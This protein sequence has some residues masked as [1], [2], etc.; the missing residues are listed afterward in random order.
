MRALTILSVVF[1]AGIGVGFYLPVPPWAAVGALATAAVAVYGSL[2]LQ[3]FTALA[4][5]AT[6]FACGWARPAVE[7]ENPDHRPLPPCHRLVQGRLASPPT[8]L[9]ERTRLVLD[10]ESW[11]A[12]LSSPKVD[13]LTAVKGRLM[14]TIAGNGPVMFRPGDRL[15]LRAKIKSVALPSNPGVEANPPTSPFFTAFVRS[16]AAIALVEAGAWN[17]SHY[18]DE[19]RR[20][21]AAFWHRVLEPAKANMARALTL[22][23]TAALGHAARQCFRRTGTA[24]LLSVSG[25]H[26]GLVV[27]FAYSLIRFLLIRITPLAQRTDVG[28]IAAACA[29]PAAVSFALL[30][31]CRIPVVRASVMATSALGA[32]MSSRP[33]GTLEAMAIA[34][35]ALLIWDPKSLFDP[36]FQLSFAAVI[37]FVATLPT[38]REEDWL[39]IAPVSQSKPSLFRRQGLI[40]YEFIRVLFRS[41]LAAAAATTPIV[42]VHFGYVSLVAV[43]ANVVAV[44]L[45]GF[46]IMPGLLVA[47]LFAGSF[48]VFAGWIGKL[49]G[50]VLGVL[51]GFL[52]KISYLPCTLENPG[53]LMQCAVV[54][55]SAGI[56]FYLAQ[57]VR[58]GIGCAIA[59]V[60]FCTA[61]WFMDPPPFPAGKLTVDFLDVGQGDATLITFPNGAHWLVDSGGSTSTWYDVGERIVV[62][63][64]R[65]LG[66]TRIDKLILT[67]PDRDHVGG[68]PALLRAVDV[69]EIWENGQGEAE[70]ADDTYH[71]ALR[72]ARVRGIAIR[73]TPA[74]CGDLSVSGVRASVLHPCSRGQSYDPTLS[75]NDNSL[76]LQLSY[77]LVT[78][79]LPGDIEREVEKF[80]AER[81]SLSPVDV[82]KLPHH[83]SR[84]SSS[85]AFLDTTKP[86]IA[87]ASLGL[88][89]PYGIPHQSVQRRLRERKTTLLRT[90]RRGAVRLVTDGRQIKIWALKK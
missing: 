60:V 72:M 25:L 62:P 39:P 34:A 46:L 22:G 83:G 49:T 18:F 6:A 33:A 24:H 31:G 13:G 30:A 66:V 47:T 75:F 16:A 9:E 68:A 50:A 74:I 37:G 12:C 21:R 42:L 40:L 65:S 77:G 55:G 57:K 53:P 58:A 10:L 35:I 8:S 26:L 5:L 56:L 7:S 54:A 70:G 15:R 79:L 86:G 89:N 64:L 41:S 11:S 67:H 61:A 3:R 4:V 69:G 23:E 27:L 43:P 73:R 2:C 80:L 81:G 45:A 51:S 59:A 85:V 44:P 32:R 14:V 63:V 78:L 20:H 88:F 19:V 87:V 36:G 48:P 38:D 52:E 82:L 17:P 84:T 90:D 1:T 76:V 29:V 28:R 71:R